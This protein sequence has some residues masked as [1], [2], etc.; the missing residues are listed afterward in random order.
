LESLKGEELLW[1][2][3]SFLLK[4]VAACQKGFE[5]IASDAKAALE[6]KKLLEE[7]NC[8]LRDENEKLKDQSRQLSDRVKTLTDQSTKQQS[9]IDALKQ[10]LQKSLQCYEECCTELKDMV[11]QYDVQ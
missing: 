11:T 8:K 4:G 10:E 9:A 2:M 6:D 7:E 5:R 1:L 3:E